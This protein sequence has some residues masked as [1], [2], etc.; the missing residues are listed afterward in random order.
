MNKIFW[1]DVETTG[2]DSSINEIIQLACIIEVDGIVKERKE[3]K[4]RP[5]DFNN[6]NPEALQVT[7]FTIEQLKLFPESKFVFLEFI[8]FLDKYIDKFDRSD[9]FSIGAYNGK[10]DCDF[11]QNF[12]KK[13][14]HKYYGS[15]FNYKLID[16]LAIVRWLEYNQKLT[17]LENNKLETLARHFDIKIDAHD[18]LSDIEATMVLERKLKEFLK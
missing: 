14:N 5:N 15:Y 12:F 7:G 8:K 13:H 18:A 6:I 11:L 2:L 10:F 1:F 3:W 16:P 9:K 4:V 17:G